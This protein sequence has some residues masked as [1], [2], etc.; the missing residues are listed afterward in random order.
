MHFNASATYPADPAAV[1]QLFANPDFV[2]AKIAA[3]G[4]RDS[5]KEVSG[6][7]AAAFTVTT[8]RTLPAEVV[9]PQYRRFVSGGVTLTLTEAWAAPRG[10]GSRGGD[11]H[12]TIAG[13]PASATGTCSLD[14]AGEDGAVLA[15]E[16]EVT[17]SIPLF[18]AKVERA[19]VSALEHVMALEREVASSWLHRT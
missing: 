17:V 8:T 4:A 6:D 11:L 15:Y 10:D 19:A 12:L 13:A 9:P 16:G 3:S 18:G 1:A 2:D 5:V 7:P 14:P